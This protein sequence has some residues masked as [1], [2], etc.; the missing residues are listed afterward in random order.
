M[1]LLSSCAANGFTANFRAD[2]TDALLGQ[3]EEANPDGYAGWWAAGQRLD[4]SAACSLAL[5]GAE[6]L[7]RAT[8]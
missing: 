7:G 1:T 4:P 3:A 2:V 5:S 6:Q 8:V